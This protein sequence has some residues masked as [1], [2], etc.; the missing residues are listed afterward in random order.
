M[1]VVAYDV[2]VD[3]INFQAN[4]SKKIKKPTEADELFLVSAKADC[5]CQLPISFGIIPDT[6]DHCE[7]ILEISND[8]SIGQILM[9][10]FVMDNL[11]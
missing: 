9:M 4:I 8:I 10:A 7:H 6:Q 5:S 2:V 3:K 1:E 11:F